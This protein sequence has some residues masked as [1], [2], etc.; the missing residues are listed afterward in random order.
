MK[1]IQQKLKQ[2]EELV[3]KLKA[4]LEAEKS[5]DF[6]KIVYN[7][8]EFRIYKWENKPFRDFLIPEGFNFAEAS[9]IDELVNLE[10]F[11]PEQ[12]LWY[13]FK[14]RYPKI[15]KDYSLSRLYL[16]GVLSLRSGDE[17]LDCSDSGGRVIISRKLKS[18]SK[19]KTNKEV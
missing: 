6:I 12:E 15:N 11:K 3:E 18:L 10:I 2:A 9:L 17:Y 14:Q 16:S 13:V 7:Q 4:K 8:T 19:H 1:T 5:K